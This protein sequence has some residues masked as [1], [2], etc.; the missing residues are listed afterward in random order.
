MTHQRILFAFLL[1]NFSISKNKCV[2]L[3]PCDIVNGDMLIFQTSLISHDFERMY[4]VIYMYIA[5]Y[6]NDK[7]M[8]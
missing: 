3:F 2:Y 1:F 8:I 5:V 6:V 7:Y 4:Y